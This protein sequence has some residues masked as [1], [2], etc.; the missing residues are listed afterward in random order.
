MW[1]VFL[2]LVLVWCWC[3]WV[4]ACSRSAR[5]CP[6]HPIAKITLFNIDSFFLSTNSYSLG[7]STCLTSPSRTSIPLWPH[8]PLMNPCS[9][10]WTKASTI[11]ISTPTASTDIA[12]SPSALAI[13]LVWFPAS[14]GWCHPIALFSDH[15]RTISLQSPHLKVD[16]QNQDH[17]VWVSRWFRWPSPHSWCCLQRTT[18][19]P[20]TFALLPYIFSLV[21]LSDVH[22]PTSS[23]WSCTCSVN[24]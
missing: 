11:F 20:C 14:L 18:R 7:F 9:D 8:D 1:F 17:R 23:P 19:L 2:R 4:L 21:T 6:F 10:Y 16:E 3:L 5:I 12:H 15:R 22:L 24:K 13:R